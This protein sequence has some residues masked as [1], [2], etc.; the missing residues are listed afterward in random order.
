MPVIHSRV[1]KQTYQEIL[2]KVNKCLSGW[3]A[4][5]LSLVRRL[6][7]TQS[8]IQTILIYAMQTTKIPSGIRDNIDQA[9]RHFIW[10]GVAGKKKM[11]LV[12]WDHIYQ[13]KLCG[14]LGLKNLSLMNE[15]LLMKIRWGLIYSPN[16]LWV[17]VLLSKYTLNHTSLPNVLPMK[18]GSYMWKVVA[19]IWPEVLKG[20]K[21]DIGNGNKVR[22]WWDNWAT[23]EYPLHAFASQPIPLEQVN[24][25]IARF[26]TDE[27]AWNWR[28][29]ANFLIVAI[30]PLNMSDEDDQMYWAYSK[31]GGFTTKSAYLAL[32]KMTIND[33]DSFWSFVWHWRGPQRIRTFLWVVGQNRLKTKAELF[34]RHI[35]ADMS[36]AR[37]GCLIENTLHALRDC[38]GAK[39]FFNLNL[40]DWMLYNLKN[41]WKYEG[42]FY[43]TCLF[44]VTIWRL[45]FWRNQNLH[46]GVTNSTS[47]IVMDIKCR[48]EEI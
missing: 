12:K 34:R 36:C 41:L 22:F 31:S 30:K 15:A 7:L 48:T 39:H 23:E 20:I 24:E 19:R 4:M 42:F 9:C 3:N 25:C 11:S 2:D 43:W 26:I 28:L 13:L 35:G 33:E 44:G 6:I 38:P 14:G 1:N 46:N 8:V 47:H 45:W 37:C 5:H 27:G 10:S 40:R 16:S 21:W 32:S 17:Q 18:Y 29:F